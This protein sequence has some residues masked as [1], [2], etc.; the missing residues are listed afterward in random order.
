MFSV[1]PLEEQQSINLFKIDFR[2]R[3]QDTKFWVIKNV[4]VN[5]KQRSQV[6]VLCEPKE[7]C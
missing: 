3:C 4:Y 1:I 6:R 2:G 7:G 5:R